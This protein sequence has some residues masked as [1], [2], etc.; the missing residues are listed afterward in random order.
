MI[1]CASL[2]L[3]LASTRLIKVTSIKSRQQFAKITLLA[4]IFCVTVVSGNTSL[5]YIP[6]SFNQAIGATTPVFTAAIASIILGQRETKEVYLAL[7]PVVVGIIIASGAE[8]MFQLAGFTAAV[9]AT[10]AR[11]FK[12]VL[13]GLM[14]SDSSDNM[15]SLSLLMYMAPIAGAILIP[16][17]LY[18]EPNAM[19]TAWTLG[20]NGSK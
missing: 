16:A 13:Q 2:S 8:P 10:A 15:D 20:A 3:F 6:V 17:T 14:L 7:V 5:R 4:I 9:T 11:A 1:A 12:S 19:G 18:F